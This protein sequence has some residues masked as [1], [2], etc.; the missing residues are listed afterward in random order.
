[1]RRAPTWLLALFMGLAVVAAPAPGEARNKPKVAWKTVEAPAGERHD[2]LVRALKPLL[3]SAARKANFGEG[4]RIVLNARIV[5]FTSTASGD[6]HRVSC[7]LI[8]RIQGGATA[9]SRISF[10]GRPAERAA[11]EKQVLTMV[12]NGVVSRLAE[13]VRV[14]A[15]AEK[16]RKAESEK[17]EKAKKAAAENTDAEDDAAE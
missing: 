9:K 5:H 4:K 6:V 13:I 11:L 15:A 10:G 2:Q 3:Q 1:M 17:V 14:S 8:G 16:A 7:T 12:A